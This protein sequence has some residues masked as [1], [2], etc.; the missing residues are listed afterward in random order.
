MAFCHNILHFCGV[1]LT[2]IYEK[3]MSR[4]LEMKT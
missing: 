2:D 1:Y 3:N 4:E